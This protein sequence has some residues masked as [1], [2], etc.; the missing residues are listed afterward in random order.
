M[1][2]PRTNKELLSP[3][4]QLPQVWSQHFLNTFSNHTYS[5]TN[6][7]AYAINALVTAQA[8]SGQINNSTYQP[9]QGDK[10]YHGGASGTTI[11]I[12]KDNHTIITLIGGAGSQGGAHAASRS[13]RGSSKGWSGWS[14][15][16]NYKQMAQNGQSASFI[17]TLR[18]RETL[19]FVYSNN[20]H[21]V[22]NKGMHSISVIY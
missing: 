15:Y 10:Y 1:D 14:H 6:P 2:L 17:T 20:P 7:N 9:N 4:N 5:Y 16:G 3:I 12:K 22:A 8:G 21:S 18:P 11:T 13:W 19:H